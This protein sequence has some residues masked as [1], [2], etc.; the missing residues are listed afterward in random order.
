MMESLYN[1]SLFFC[2]NKLPKR[3]KIPLVLFIYYSSIKI[4][5]LVM[6][7]I[8]RLNKLYVCK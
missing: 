7:L 3:D 4:I 5:T 6:C 2:F 8:D 1:F